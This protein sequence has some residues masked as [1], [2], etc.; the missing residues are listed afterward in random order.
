[1]RKFGVF[2]ALTLSWITASCAERMVYPAAIPKPL[3]PKATPK[4]QSNNVEARRQ[5]EKIV[6]DTRRRSAIR[7][8]Q[9]SPSAGVK[10]EQPLGPRAPLPQVSLQPLETSI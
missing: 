3:P 1:M 9:V 2:A 4:L 7:S 10:P 6:E 5:A 8:R